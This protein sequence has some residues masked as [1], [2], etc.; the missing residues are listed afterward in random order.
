ML[1]NFYQNE[2]KNLEENN[3]MTDFF[4]SIENE[5]R[6]RNNEIQLME[7]EIKQNEIEDFWINDS[8]IKREKMKEKR[9][10]LEYNYKLENDI[11]KKENNHFLE[12]KQIEDEQNLNLFN[13]EN[14]HRTNINKLEMKSKKIDME[15]ANKI[16]E[17]K[18]VINKRNYKYQLEKK[19]LKINIKIL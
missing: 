16:N 18:N 17:L 19:K 6:R 10:L 5:K 9:R 11:Q 12:L 1:D 3:K 14:I 15:N 2:L 13:L 8:K 4:L 7:Q